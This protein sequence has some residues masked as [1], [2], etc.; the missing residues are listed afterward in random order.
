MLLKYSPYKNL[1]DEADKEAKLQELMAS[2]QGENFSVAKASAKKKQ[3]HA[4]AISFG[5]SMSLVRTQ[6]LEASP[7]AT[8]SRQR[9]SVHAAAASPS[10]NTHASRPEV[11]I[12]EG[13]IE[14]NH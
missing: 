4:R 5:N 1:E 12:F 10:K 13:L 11:E 6:S 7:S 9:K 14:G 8:K 3:S 2:S